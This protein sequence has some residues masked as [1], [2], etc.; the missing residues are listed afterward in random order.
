MR[1][2]KLSLAAL[3]ATLKTHAL[4]S[5]HIDDIPVIRMFTISES[6]LKKRAQKLVRLI[7]KKSPFLSVSLAQD[8]SQVGGGACPMHNLVTWVVVI[9]PS[10]LTVNEF[11]Y[12]LRQSTPP[13]ISRINRDSILLDMRTIF[14]NEDALIPDC[15]DQVINMHKSI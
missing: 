2:D 4:N 10:P 1:I 12:L 14:S 7:K 15:V 8:K 13:V 5:K 9:N 3:E 11:E 6:I